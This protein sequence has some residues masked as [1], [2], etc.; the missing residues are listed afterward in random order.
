MGKLL[1]EGTQEPGQNIFTNGQTGSQLKPAL[2]H[3]REPGHAGFRLPHELN[4]PFSK[5][6]ERPPRFGKLNFFGG[7]QKQLGPEIILQRLDLHGHRRLSHM[8]RLGRSGEAALFGNRIKNMQLM[9]I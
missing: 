2:Q 1:P 4:A 5:G 3:M 6:K 8:Q 9:E 7:A